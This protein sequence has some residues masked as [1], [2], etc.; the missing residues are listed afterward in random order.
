MPTFI[1]QRQKVIVAISIVHTPRVEIV[2][3]LCVLRLPR[4]T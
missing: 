1:C 3:K 2:E 4:R